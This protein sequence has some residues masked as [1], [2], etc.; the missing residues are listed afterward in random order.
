M[1]LQV[2]AQ[3][4]KSTTSTAKITKAMKMVAA[5]KL[6]GAE[7]TMLAA[8]PFSQSVASLMDPLLAVKEDDEAPEKTLFVAISSDKGL[9]GGINS[10][11]VKECKLSIDTASNSSSL[12]LIGSKARDGLTRTHGK[13]IET[14]IDEV[15]SM[16]NSFSLAS[17]LAEQVLAKPVDHYTLIFNKF[18]S[19]ISFDVEPK[20]IKGPACLGESGVCDEYEFEGDKEDVLANLYQ[21]HIATQIYSS[22][23]ENTTSEQASRMTAMDSATTNANDMIDKLTVIFNRK[24]QAKITTE[25][26]E[27][28]AGAESV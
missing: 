3:R 24:R 16:P 27:I 28:V 2:L 21:F 23:L 15:Y 13:A 26:T 18:K 9:C 17:F 25:L 22:M 8:R 12:F 1:S 7:R 4:I 14:S 11:V 19:V 5:A 20:T 6:K 10:R